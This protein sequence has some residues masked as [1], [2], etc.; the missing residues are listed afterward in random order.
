M[1]TQHLLLLIVGATTFAMA[2]LALCTDI[3]PE[4]LLLVPMTGTTLM[5]AVQGRKDPK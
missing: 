2:F 1:K 5:L 4:T 3:E